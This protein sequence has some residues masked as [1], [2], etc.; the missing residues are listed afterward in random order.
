VGAE[1]FAGHVVLVLQVSG[2]SAPAGQYFPAGHMDMAL[3]PVTDPP[4]QYE[5]GTHWAHAFSEP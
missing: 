2:A 4:M 1:E 5:P 3:G